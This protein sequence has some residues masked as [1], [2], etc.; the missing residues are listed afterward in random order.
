MTRI[1]I[2]L[3]ALLIGVG[4]YATWRGRHFLRSCLAAGSVVAC[5]SS[6]LGMNTSTVADAPRPA[7]ATPAAAALTAVPY[8]PTSLWN[9]R[10]GPDPRIAS[11]SAKVI[12]QEFADGNTQPVRNQEPGVYDYGH[13]IYFATATDPLVNLQ[14]TRYCGS[15]YPKSMRVPAIARPAGGSD[16]HMAV[17]Q[18][19]MTE[20]DM[21]GVSKP[22]A[23]YASGQTI[24][25]ANV[26]NCG[27][28]VTGSGFAADIGSTAGQA[29]LGAGLLRASELLSGHINHA[30]FLVAQCVIGTQRPTPPSAATGQC[31]N[32]IGPPLGGRLWA[33]VA[34]P[35]GLPPWS[36]AIWNALHT[37]G[38]YL[39]DS[40]PTSPNIQGIGFLSSSGEQDYVYGAPDPYAA[41]AAQGWS[42][43]PI[44]GSLRPRWAGADR[45]NPPGLTEHLHWLAPS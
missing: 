33:D 26:A 18:P 28:Y 12:A 45:W 25:A 2:A 40:S 8:G 21:W 15:A 44:T 10:V 37:Y 27:S 31:A 42:S 3:L 38:G 22:A 14:C 13:P 1:L 11:Y 32:G 34:A 4:G 17:I 16:S 7:I 20:I 23:N 36:A 30:L 24:V 41:L 6:A 29:C 9:L 5:G 19:D 35:S 43:I 39:M